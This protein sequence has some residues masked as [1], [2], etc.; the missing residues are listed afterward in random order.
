MKTFGEVTAGANINKTKMSSSVYVRT[1]GGGEKKGKEPCR[2]SQT[3][4][5]LAG[6]EDKS[7]IGNP[8]LGEDLLRKDLWGEQQSDNGLC[9]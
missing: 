8:C 6:R 3:V 5:T 7:A 2:E 1:S 9:F 4:G